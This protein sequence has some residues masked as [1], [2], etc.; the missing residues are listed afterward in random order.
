V[1]ER[2]REREKIHR[3]LVI[4]LLKIASNSRS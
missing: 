4:S 3:Y 1:R 2:E